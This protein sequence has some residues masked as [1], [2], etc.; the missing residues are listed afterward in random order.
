MLLFS[1]VLSQQ[2]DGSVKNNYAVRGQGLSGKGLAASL[3]RD[4]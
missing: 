3:H 4:S 2:E 1:I